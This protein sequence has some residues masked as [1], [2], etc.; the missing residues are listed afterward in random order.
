MGEE[1]GIAMKTEDPPAAISNIMALRL[2]R[3]EHPTTE[4]MI[5][6]AK[7]AGEMLYHAQNEG[8]ERWSELGVQKR[9]T[10]KDQHAPPPPSPEKPLSSSSAASFSAGDT[11]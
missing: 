7:I 5:A 1:T 3:V 6:Q 9:E 2:V 10:I 8:V 4:Q 11:P